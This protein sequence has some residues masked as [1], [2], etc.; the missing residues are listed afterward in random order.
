MHVPLLSVSG[1]TGT[2]AGGAAGADV[3]DEPCASS[4]ESS[5]AKTNMNGQLRARDG[6]AYSEFGERGRPSIVFLHGI[7]L[8]REIWDAHARELARTYHVVTI[9]LPGHGDAA[10]VAFTSDGVAEILDH[11]ME[12]V[13]SPK[14]LVVGYSLGGYVTM[15]HAAAHPDRTSALLLAGCTLDFESWKHWPYEL[16]VRLSQP[17]PGDLLDRLMRLSLHLVLP[18]DWAHL[19]AGIPFDRDVFARTSEL[20]RKEARFSD[21]LRAYR[22]P[23]LFVNGEYD[24]VF[25]L[26]ERRFLKRVPQ[27][28][29]RVIR[30]AAH[31]APMRRSAEFT[32]IVRE[33]AG[34][35]FGASS[36]IGV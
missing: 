28:R 23:V 13:A 26:D 14:P 3:G 11:V 19:V 24:V 2:V 8:G 6:I 20:A 29:R 30:G 32:A 12:R 36:P 5:V 31:T 34:K 25:R 33:F 27:A 10:R 7:R 16:S 17:I 1:P 18:R 4:T 21:K 9:D 15:Q 22:N 35:V